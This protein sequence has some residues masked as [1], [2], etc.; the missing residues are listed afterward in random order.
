MAFKESG[1]KWIEGQVGV[2]GM[3]SRVRTQ[4]KSFRD[5]FKNFLSCL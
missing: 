4:S 3:L 2:R 1:F 5:D